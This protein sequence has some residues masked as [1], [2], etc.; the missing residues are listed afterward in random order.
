MF[1]VFSKWNTELM[2]N[3]NFSLFVANGKGKRQTSV[4]LLQTGMENGSLLSLFG[5]R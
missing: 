1:P 3:E 5:K 2:E 4:C